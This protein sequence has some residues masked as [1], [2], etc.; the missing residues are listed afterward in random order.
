MPNPALT[1]YIPACIAIAILTPILSGCA[2]AYI[3][4]RREAK[5]G[6]L[7]YVGQSQPNRPSICYNSLTS[8][9]QEV[10]ALAQKVCDETGTKAVPV[11]GEAL[12]C[13]AFYPS[14]VTY[15]CVSTADAAAR[16]YRY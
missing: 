11:K 4:R 8:T 15:Q 3:D 13:T 16:G 10:A 9:P 2:G 5:D 6:Q 12:D 1:R 14:R 7:A